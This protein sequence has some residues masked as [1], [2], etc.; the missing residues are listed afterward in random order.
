[1]PFLRDWTTI[2]L[3]QYNK[4]NKKNAFLLNLRLKL[5]KRNRK[6]LDLL[7]VSIIFTLT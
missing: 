5:L 6:L 3:Y 1:M 2:F 4:Q 7:I